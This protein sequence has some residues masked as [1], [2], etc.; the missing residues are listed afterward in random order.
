GLARD[1]ERYLADEPVEACPPSA[2][3]RLKKFARKYKKA[4]AVS[5]TFAAVIVIAVAIGA[6]Q[7]HQTTSALALA[8]RRQEERALA[9]LNAL[10]EAAPGAVPA[11]LKDLA[12]DRDTVL[13]SLRKRY[14]E[15]HDRGKRMRLALALL[16][17]DPN[18]VRDDLV[19]WMLNVPDPAEMV[20][21]RN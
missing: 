14:A 7:L 17:V 5:A 2:G 8:D 4:L 19:A 16:S 13:G 20:V 12:A 9:Q 1:I 21:M 6:W 3:Y 15:E 11:I 18:S 10:C